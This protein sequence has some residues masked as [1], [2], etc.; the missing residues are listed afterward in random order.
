MKKA[1]KRAKEVGQVLVLMFD[2]EDIDMNLLKDILIKCGEK[3]DSI[4]NILIN[5]WINQ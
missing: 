3:E 1:L 2:P 5:R 4:T